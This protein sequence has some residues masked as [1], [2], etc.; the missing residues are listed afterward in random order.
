MFAGT[1]NPGQLRDRP[2]NH[3]R[4]DGRATSTP[5]VTRAA[6]ANTPSRPPRTG[7][8]SSRMRSR[9]RSTAPTVCATSRRC[10]SPTA[11]RSTSSSA[12]RATTS[13]NGTAQ[14]D[15]ILGLAGADT[16]N[17]LAGNDILVG[18]PR[19]DDTAARMPTTS[20]AASF[21]NSNGTAQLGP[22][23][24]ETGDNGSAR[25]TGQIRHR[26]RRQQRSRASH[27][28]GDGARDHSAR[29]ISPARRPPA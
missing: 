15:L 5:P 17:G 22:D 4:H 6:A 10:S 24:V 8:S 14:D 7:R 28:T 20:T 23:W 27:G 2:R 25:P 11:T 19:H 16:L 13:L 12:R 29:S 18:G 9:T 3:D 1:I 21:G 26:R